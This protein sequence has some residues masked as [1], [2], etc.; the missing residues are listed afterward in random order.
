MNFL[1]MLTNCVSIG[2]VVG[3]L[4]GAGPGL[5]NDILPLAGLTLFISTIL[6]LFELS[7]L[8]PSTPVAVEPI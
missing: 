6:V 4:A 5:G 3:F 2:F 7:D 1:S 8:E